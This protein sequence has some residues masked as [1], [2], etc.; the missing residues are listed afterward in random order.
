MS[1]V[2]YWLKGEEFEIDRD[3][4][5]LSDRS[6]M[7]VRRSCEVKWWLNYHAGPDGL[8]IESAL[9]SEDL[10]VGQAV[11]TGL[12]G[13]VGSVGVPGD[14]SRDWP[15]E[16]Y[17]YVM[18]KFNSGEL[19]IQ[20]DDILTQSLPELATVLAEEQAWLAYAL[21]W[22]FGRRHLSSLLEEYEVVGLEME[23][24]WLLGTEEFTLDCRDERDELRFP[25]V[26][27]MMSRLD[28]LLRSKTD[29]KLYILEYKTKKEFDL[30]TA[31]GLEISS[32]GAAQMLAAYN[33]FGEYPAGVL[34][35]YLLK[36]EKR[37]DKE[38]GYKRYETSIVR[39]YW[40]GH[41]QESTDYAFSYWFEK[42][43]GNKGRLG[44]NWK[45]VDIWKDR[46]IGIEQWLEMLDSGEIQPQLGT[47]WLDGV[48]VKP[49]LI[50]WSKE[51]LAKW[52]KGAVAH[53][54]RYVGYRDGSK[55]VEELWANDDRCWEWRQRC[56]FFPI[57]HEGRG[58][59]E[60]LMS[61]RYKVR[62]P[63]HKLELEEVS[64]VGIDH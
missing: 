60:M 59:E 23:I 7:L 10:I 52:L 28:G 33:R 40:S 51:R 58:V 38:L 22:T 18:E 3:R 37:Q 9:E 64:D 29:G 49:E 50:V 47:D 15:G 16:A 25:H 54:R 53:E 32:Q 36:G 63:N 44:N 45:R 2:K 34:Y 13:V 5:S 57:C 12:E 8:G 39:P 31:Q 21:V 61:G 1:S 35:Y 20:G 11:H 55:D 62:E 48:I 46:Q 43:D 56:R 6:R 27:I 26:I 24:P 4:C 17:N 42:A 30:E 41:G 19:L 14:E